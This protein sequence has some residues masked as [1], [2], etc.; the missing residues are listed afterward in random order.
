MIGVLLRHT[1]GQRWTV[2]DRQLRH[3]C[4]MVSII[5]QVMIDEHR[6]LLKVISFTQEQLEEIGSDK[7]PSLPWDPGVHFVST[8]LMLTQVAPESHTLHLGLVW[9][10][11]AS[12]CPM[13]RDPS[14]RVIIMIGNGD[15]WIGT[16]ST[17]MPLQIQFLDSRSSGHRCFS[18][19][20]Q[21]RRIQ[22]VCKGM[23][24]KVIVVQCQHEDL[25]QR[26]AWDPGIAGLRS[27]LTDREEWTIAG[28]IYSNFPLIFG[29]ERSASLA[30]ASRRSCITSI[31]HH[32]VQLMEAVWILVE[33]WRMDSFLDE[34]MC[35][36]QEV[37]RVDIFQD[38]ASQRRSIRDPLHLS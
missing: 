10:G 28:E 34:A 13:G 32:H 4:V 22:D 31:G 15:V 36:V 9:S 7:L 2:L 25:R 12:T 26:L 27:S 20:T 6:G 37:H 29:V 14:F 21:E 23:I 18:L 5:D 24:V 11:S 17:E 30:G 3:W 38:Y 35:H 33:I 16:S 19:R 1:V 8:M